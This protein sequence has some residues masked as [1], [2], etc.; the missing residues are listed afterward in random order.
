IVGNNGY[1]MAHVHFAHDCV[2]GNNVTLANG[3]MCAGHVHIGD[4]VTMGGACGIT[5]FVSVGKGAFIGAASALDKDIPHF[6]AALGNRIRLKGVNIIGMKRRGYSKD[7]ISEVV[8]FYR[9]MEASALSPKAFVEHPENIEDYKNNSV[10]Q[11]LIEFISGSEIG[12]PP[13][14]S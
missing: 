1:F 13:F 12:L 4:Y 11:E 9:I 8:E 2:I 5:P 6:C 3:V 7:E 14:M 10:I